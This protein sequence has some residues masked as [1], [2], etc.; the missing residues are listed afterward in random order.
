MTDMY[1]DV[2]LVVLAVLA[3]VSGLSSSVSV[4]LA[5]RRSSS[6]SESPTSRT[7]SNPL[8]TSATLIALSSDTQTAIPPC[9]R[10]CRA[11]IL[12]WLAYLRTL[13]RRLRR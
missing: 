10:G 5:K 4:S 11:C 9:Y 2:L 3:S 6:K 8:P 1:T 12:T 7:I 13:L